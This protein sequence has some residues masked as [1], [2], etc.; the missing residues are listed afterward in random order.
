[1]KTSSIIKLMI[2]SW[3]AVFLVVGLT[4]LVSTDFMNPRNAEAID[5]CILLTGTDV[6]PAG[7]ATIWDDCL[8]QVID[9]GANAYHS[10]VDTFWSNYLRLDTITNVLNQPMSSWNIAF[11]FGAVVEADSAEVYS[12]DTVNNIVIDFFSSPF[13]IKSDKWARKIITQVTK[14]KVT[15]NDSLMIT[16]I[17]PDSLSKYLGPYCFFRFIVT[18]SVGSTKYAT[19]GHKDTTTIYLTPALYGKPRSY[20]VH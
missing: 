6:Q 10:K 3:S 11:R 18:D 16:T 15:T 17:H 20:W 12:R 1:M 14:S 4:I 9:S 8:Y 7:S 2:G 5:L 19:S 13:Q